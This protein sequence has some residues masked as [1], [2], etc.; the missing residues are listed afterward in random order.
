MQAGTMGTASEVCGWSAGGL[1]RQDVHA[2]LDPYLCVSRRA[3]QAPSRDSHGDSAKRV[4]VACA[5][6]IRPPKV[7]RSRVV[8]AARE[9]C[10]TRLRM[11]VLLDWAKY[12]G[13]TPGRWANTLLCAGNHNIGDRDT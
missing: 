10:R 13:E 4:R 11:C 8:G 9:S 5:C 3:R 1:P 6:T 7:C 2:A 12:L